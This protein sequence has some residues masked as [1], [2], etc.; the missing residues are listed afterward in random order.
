MDDVIGVGVGQAT[1]GFGEEGCFYLRS[2]GK[3]K[4]EPKQDSSEL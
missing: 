3:L 2:E 1:A 4:E